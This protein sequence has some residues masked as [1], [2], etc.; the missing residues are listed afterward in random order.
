MASSINVKVIFG[1]F[2]LGVAGENYH[3]IFNY[4][5][6]GMESLVVGGKEWLYRT[7]KPTY[8]R[9]TTD[10]DRGSSFHL[11]SGV[12]MSADM[13]QRATGYDVVMDG[14]PVTALI[15]PANNCWKGEVEAGEI[16]ITYHFSTLTV[17]ST[18]VHV[19]YTATA[20][21]IR[22]TAKYDGCEGLP[23][24]PAFGMRMI[25]PTKA[26]GFTYEGLSGETYPDRKAGGVPGV[27]TV[28]GLP[29]TP[30]MVPQECGMHVDTEWVEISRKTAL[31]NTCLTCD[32]F[33]LKIA[34]ADAPLSFSCLPY[35][36]E[37]LENATH[38]EELPPARRTVL[39][40]YG[41]VRGVG[42]INSWG[43]DVEPKYHIDAARDITFSF[44]ICM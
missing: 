14:E 3:A 31:D 10:N 24:L 33:T 32:P 42:G 9:A 1:D 18:T 43:A 44:D 6:G 39:C 12:W 25:M 37:E 21:R 41:A 28:E 16:A 22:V 29:V 19:T 13:F 36:S 2:T 15:A 20:D 30:Y 34:K 4:G 35:T 11:K 7:M 17:P 27:Y 26:I 38:H 40:V 23:Q 5:T 8:W